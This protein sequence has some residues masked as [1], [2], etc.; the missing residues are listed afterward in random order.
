VIRWRHRS[1]ARQAARCG[2]RGVPKIPLVGDVA[3]RRVGGTRVATEKIHGAPLVI[4]FD[5]RELRIGKRRAWL[6][7]DEP[8]FGW[9]LLRPRFAAAAS[10][11]RDGAGLDHVPLLARGRCP[12]N[13][14]G[15]AGA[16]TA[17]R[18]AL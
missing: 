11:A 8:F 7:A 16:V 2:A 12:L 1:S 5:G 15:E 13:P 10:A 9:Q 3:A 18:A 14:K 4:A 17:I 6:A